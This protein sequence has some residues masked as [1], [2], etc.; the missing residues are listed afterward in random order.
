MLELNFAILMVQ[1]IS[2]E[3]PFVTWLDLKCLCN[4]PWIYLESSKWILLLASTAAK[5]FTLENPIELGD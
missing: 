4:R 3:F 1:R 5:G 2:L